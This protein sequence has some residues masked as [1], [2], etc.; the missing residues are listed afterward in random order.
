MADLRVLARSDAPRIARLL[1]ARPIDNIFIASRLDKLGVARFGNRLLGWFD[2]GHLISLLSDGYTLAPVAA[3]PEA[4]TAFGRQEERRRASSIV[5]QRDDAV[6]LWQELCHQ[7]YSQWAAPRQVRDHQ[8][9]MVLDHPTGYE[10]PYDVRQVGTRVVD[11]YGSAAVAMYTEEVGVAPVDLAGYRA[12]VADLMMR[13]AAWGLVVEDQV[14]FKADVVADAGDIAQIGGV[15]LTPSW[16]GRG[17]SEPL[18]AGVVDAVRRRWPTV[19]L[20]VNPWNLPA[21]ACYRRIGFHQVSECAT[22][23]Y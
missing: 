19:T 21:I 23:L 20:Y 16:R 13:G 7:S 14:V 5:G 22:V 17:L 8:L 6:G 9:V 3:T 1:N 18:M 11:S 4:L 2:H 10:C 15:W 12:H